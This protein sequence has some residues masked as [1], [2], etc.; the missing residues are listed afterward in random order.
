M[1]KE[2]ITYLSRFSPNLMTASSTPPM[3]SNQAARGY[4]PHTPV[5]PVRHEKL[6][7][8]IISRTMKGKNWFVDHLINLDCVKLYVRTATRKMGSS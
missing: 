3:S 7:Y 5:H 8:C 1:G 6:Y 2:V 4:M